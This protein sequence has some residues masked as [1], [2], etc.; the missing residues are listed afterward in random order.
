MKRL[1]RKAIDTNLEKR[2]FKATGEILAK[3]GEEVVLY[4]FPVVADY[5]KNAAKD[6]LD[7][8]EKWI[9]VHCRIS[10]YLLQIVPFNFGDFQTT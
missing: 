4:N 3:V 8:N 10:Q 5:V 7:L 6:P 2:N 9:S 1:G